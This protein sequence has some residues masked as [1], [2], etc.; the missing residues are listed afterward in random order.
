MILNAAG[1]EHD[2]ERPLWRPGRR[3]F[4]FFGFSAAVAPFLPAIHPTPNVLS[5][6]WSDGHSPVLTYEMLEQFLKTYYHATP[7]RPQP[8]NTISRMAK[9]LPPIY[10]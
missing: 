3:A 5:A 1:E 7:R 2:P 10:F 8:I 4:F 6:V 9:G